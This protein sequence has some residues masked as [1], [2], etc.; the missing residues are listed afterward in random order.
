VVV[1]HRIGIGIDEWT[2]LHYPH[3]IC[4]RTTTANTQRPKL[5][6]IA[7]TSHVCGTKMLDDTSVLRRCLQIAE[8]MT[9]IS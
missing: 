4:S 1:T 5:R 8:K 6:M 7:G 3:H 9:V 2:K